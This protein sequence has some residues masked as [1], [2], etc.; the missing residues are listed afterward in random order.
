MKELVN[1][2]IMPLINNGNVSVR[3]MNNLI[4]LK[5]FIDSISTKNYIDLKTQEDI[6]KKYGVMPDIITWGDY[7]QTTLAS[8][9]I[10]LSDE[11][12]S[13]VLDTVKYDM[14]SSYLIFTEKEPDFF[15]WVDFS[16]FEIV[17]KRKDNFTKE[18]EEI[19][20]LKILKDYYTDLG[21]VDN[22]SKSLLKWYSSFKEALAI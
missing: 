17:A 3:R 6:V 15:E 14:V 12:F 10:D 7:F 1:E 9:L 2:A 21:I 22:F 19:V 13:K 18:E 11:E 8:S 20:H 16:F 5:I 4:D